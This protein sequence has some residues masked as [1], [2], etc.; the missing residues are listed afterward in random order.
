MPSE[1]CESLARDGAALSKN[2]TNVEF[3]RAHDIVLANAQ[4]QNR[5]LAGYCEYHHIVPRCLG[6]SDEPSNLVALSYEEHFLIH[7]LLIGFH[8]GAERRRL[9]YALSAVARPLPGRLPLDWHYPAVDEALALARLYETV[10]EAIGD[11]EYLTRQFWKR[12]ERKRIVRMLR[13]NPQYFIGGLYGSVL[14]DK[15]GKIGAALEALSPGVVAA[16]QATQPLKLLSWESLESPWQRGKIQVF[17]FAR[18]FGFI[19]PDDGSRDVFLSINRVP[20]NCYR[21]NAQQAC[22][23]VLGEGPKGQFAKSFALLYI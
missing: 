21:I 5:Q 19:K 16:Q 3:K 11:H 15:L 20:R 1:F 12:D 18:G 14:L 13:S 8:G 22:A 9:Q 4:T 7:Y 10:W 17:H 6:G 23:Y 2:W